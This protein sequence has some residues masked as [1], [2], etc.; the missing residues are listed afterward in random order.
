MPLDHGLMMYYKS[1]LAIKIQ[2]MFV[3]L[4][5]VISLLI[6][7]MIMTNPLSVKMMMVE[8]FL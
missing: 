6:S 7:S 2:K 4:G 3:S 8:S 1:P 5:G